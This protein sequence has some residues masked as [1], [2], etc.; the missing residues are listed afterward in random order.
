E[1]EAYEDEEG[2]EARPPLRIHPPGDLGPP[3]VQPAQVTHD[4]SSHHDVVEVGDHEVGVGDVDVQAHGRQEEAGE[5]ADGEESHEAED[6][7]HGGGVGDG[8]L[9]EGGRPVEDLD[10]GGD[11]HQEGKGGE[12]QARIGR[13]AGDEH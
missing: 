7:E 9:V 2:G 11:G 6:V 8:A 3:E 5:A 10:G 13:L 4:G 12:D 1:V